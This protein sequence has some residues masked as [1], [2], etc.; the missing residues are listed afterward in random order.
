MRKQT[1]MRD[2]Q[3]GLQMEESIPLIPK[4]MEKSQQGMYT[5]FI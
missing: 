1:T 5:R 4:T 2:S 3:H